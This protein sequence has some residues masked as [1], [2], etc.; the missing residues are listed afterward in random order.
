M[1]SVIKRIGILI[2]AAV[3]AAAFG[4]CKNGDQ[5]YEAGELVRAAN[6]D[7]KNIRYLYEKNEGKREELKTAMASDNAP[8]VRRICKEIVD[9]INSGGS[10]ANDALEKIDLA[11]EMDINEDYREYLEL[12]QGALK[13]Q[14][15]AFDAYRKAARKLNDEYDPKNSEKRD[16]VVAEFKKRN[17]EF[18][19]LMDTAR[20]LSGKAN[21][22]AQGVMQDPAEQ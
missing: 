17:D 13:K 15:E 21:E 3:L 9:S 4:A 6:A 12:K 19:K 20:D 1:E 16:L 7:L 8:E 18:L 2:L 5:T 10:I 14:R 11:I 22:K